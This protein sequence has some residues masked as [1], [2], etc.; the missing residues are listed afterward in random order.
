VG[1][2]IAAAGDGAAPAD[3][4]EGEDGGAGPG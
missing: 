1:K 3:T 4:A 2:A